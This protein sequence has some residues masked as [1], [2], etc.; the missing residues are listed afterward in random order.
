[1][2]WRRLSPRPIMMKRPLETVRSNL[3]VRGQPGP[4]TQAGRRMVTGKWV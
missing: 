4:Y 3:A 2:G 1:M